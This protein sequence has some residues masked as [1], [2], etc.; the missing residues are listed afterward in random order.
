MANPRPITLAL[1]LLGCSS[2][3]VKIDALSAE[4]ATDVSEEAAQDSASPSSDSI[5]D[6]T[7]SSDAQDSADPEDSGQTESDSSCDETLGREGQEALA[8][9]LSSGC[10]STQSTR[11]LC[12]SGHQR[13]KLREMISDQDC[14]LVDPVIFVHGNSDRALGGFGGW[15]PVRDAF[16]SAGHRSAELYATTYG[17]ADPALSTQYSHS[18]EYVQHIRSFIEAVLSYT[19]AEKIDVI[20]HSPWCDHCSRGN[21]WWYFT[22]L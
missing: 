11:G 12:E 5:E 21:H 19:G 16:L 18:Q 3:T 1:V 9:I 20:G 17:P 14:V 22:G 6:D 7:A 2:A 8:C 15:D 4:E 10:C 13:R